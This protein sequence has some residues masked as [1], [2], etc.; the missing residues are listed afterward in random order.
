[1]VDRSWEELQK[2][3]AEE[4]EAE[5]KWLNEGGSYLCGCDRHNPCRHCPEGDEYGSTN[6]SAREVDES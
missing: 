5:A 6:R 2:L 1:M 4:A 3:M